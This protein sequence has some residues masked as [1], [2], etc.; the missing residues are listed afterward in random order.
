MTPVPFAWA[1]FRGEATPEVASLAGERLPEVA[2]R[3]AD[4]AVATATLHWGRN[5]IYRATLTADPA[6]RPVAVKQFRDSRGGRSAAKAAKS[7]ARARE[8]AAAGIATPEPL[9]WAGSDDGATAIF[10]TPALDGFTE[11]RYL[12]R[13]RNAG[14][15]REGFPAFDVDAILGQVARLARRMHDAGFWH[16]DFSI[17]NL[18]IRP[19]AE[20][21]A[22]P[23]I[24]LLD[25]NRARRLDAVP[26]A[27][28]MRDLCRLPLDRADDRERLLS[29][30]FSGAVPT[31]A[32]ARYELARRAFL[33]RNAIKAGARGA[34]ASARKWLVPR[35]THA[36]IPPP[37]EGA[38]A[39]DKIVWDALSDQPHSHASRM[40]RARVRFADFG[41]HARSAAALVGAM[42]RIRRRY[43]ELLRREVEPF[44]WPEPGVA[45]RP[46]PENP[47]ALLAAFDELGARRALVRLHPWERSFDAEEELARE[48]AA[49][50][51][52]LA[53]ALPQTRELVRDRGRWRAA[54][55]EIAERFPRYGA[56]FQVGQAVNRS[57]W[58]VWS[59]DEYLALAADAA[60]ILRRPRPGA[61]PVE[62]FGPAVIDFEAHATAAIVNRK[63]PTLRFDGVASLLYVD[64]RGAPENEQLGF[65]TAG[66]V[67]LLAA[68]AGTGRLVDSGRQWISEVNWPLREGPHSP[69]GKSVSVGE[70]EQ[71]D[72]LARYFL[73]AGGDGLVERIDWWQLVA[74]GYGLCD[75]QADGTLRRRPAFHAFAT[76]RRELAGATCLGP[77]ALAGGARAVRFEREGRELLVAWSPGP[78]VDWA[79]D[80]A[81]ERV[82]ERDGT[83]RDGAAGPLRLTGSVGY[84]AL[85]E[86]ALTFDGRTPSPK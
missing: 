16:R 40:E 32:W 64:R 15:D 84:V 65:D 19:A 17:G 5:Y 59:H 41:S 53:F 24:R 70:E 75:P 9:L 12:L 26:V 48:L 83:R 39:R 30:Y 71:A 10:V 34:I 43:R 27:A 11:L 45:L 29:T 62:L 54:I 7:F 68:I 20:A 76:L 35:G 81:A 85:A 42:P 36:H 56:R 57:K 66:K 50:G 44:A 4:P 72:Y 86:R 60:E 63:H 77:A 74:K 55:E 2:R 38:S 22:P 49:R 14:T 33:R 1:G 6:S 8:F 3:L 52:E 73:L 31:V 51:V 25:L 46:W 78:A 61:A 69:A 23:E 47:Q 80:R 21:G 28:R 18:L 82:V 79:P 37:P 13:A 67:R 58:G